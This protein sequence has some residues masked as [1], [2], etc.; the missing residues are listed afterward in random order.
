MLG[1]SNIEACLEALAEADGAMERLR[2]RI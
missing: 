2:R 1:V